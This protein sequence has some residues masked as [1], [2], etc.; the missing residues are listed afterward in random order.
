MPRTGTLIRTSLL[1]V[2]LVALSAVADQAQYFYDELGRLTGVVDGQGNMAVYNY[3]PVG[4]LLSIE[5]FASGGQ[6]TNPIGI[7]LVTPTSALVGST[8]QIRGF[9]FS[10]TPSQNQV[11]FNG[12]SASVLSASTNAIT[13]VVPAGATSGPVTVT[14][15]SGSASSPQIFTILVPPI[16]AGAEPSRLPQGATSRVVISGF[17]LITA[18]DVVFTQSGLAASILPGATA[19]SLPVNLTVAATVP[20]GAY[21]FSVLSP[22]GTV[23]SGTIVMNV[24]PAV[25]SFSV[26]NRLSVFFPFPSQAA[27]SGSSAAVAR[28]LSVFL[29]TSEPVPTTTVAPPLSVSMP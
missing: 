13:A 10:A 23:H 6:G 3:D 14:N 29:P 4:N 9:G 1:A 12:K 21:G 26:M 7:F 27:P 15:S 2:W 25:P 11:A 18:T 5:R 22:L 16:I 8:V 17:N 24:T 19:Q 20:P 28:P